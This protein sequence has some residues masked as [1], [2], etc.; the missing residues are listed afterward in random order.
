MKILEVIH[1][2]NLRL[3]AEE[4]GGVAAA[5]AKVGCSASQ[6]SQWMNG[7]THSATGKPRGMRSSSARRIEQ[8]A[9]KPAGWMD[10]SHSDEAPAA[11]PFDENVI[12][13]HPGFR[14][15]PVIS[16]VQAGALRDMDSP[17]PPGAGYA[18][19]YTDQDLSEWGFALDVEGFSMLPEFR[20]GDRIIVDPELAPNPGD[21]VIARNGSEQATFKKYRPRGIDAAGNEIFELVPLNEDYPTLRSDTERLSVIGVVTE[22]RKKLRRQ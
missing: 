3:L 8:A 18:Y 1:K 12:P 9:G 2:E 16:S 21:F 19:E 11:Q 15:I 17:Y 10:Q 22:H 4:L 14:P 13:A 6:Y 7:S 20:P 5:A